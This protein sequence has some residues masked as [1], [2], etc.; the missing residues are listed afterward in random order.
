MLT[1][2]QD[3]GANR[4]GAMYRSDIASKMVA[5]AVGCEPVSRAFPENTGENTPIGSRNDGLCSKAQHL[6]G[7]LSKYRNKVSGHFF[8]NNRG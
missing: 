1:Q 5:D 4:N 7:F 8:R 3:Y 6:L 2:G